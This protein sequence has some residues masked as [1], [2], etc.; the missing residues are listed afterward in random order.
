[1]KWGYRKN[2]IGKQSSRNEGIAS[3]NS[4]EF[5][6]IWENVAGGFSVEHQSFKVVRRSSFESYIVDPK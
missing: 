2:P 5:V 1:M 6:S 3:C 4:T